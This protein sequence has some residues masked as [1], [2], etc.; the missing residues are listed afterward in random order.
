MDTQRLILFAVFAFSVFMLWEAWQ[1]QHQPPPPVIAQQPATQ[2]A[3][4]PAATPGAGAGAAKT[5]E[6]PGTTAAAAPTAASERVKVKT[7]LLEAVIDTRGGAIEELTLL[8]HR[9]AL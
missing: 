9:A 2:P 3:A 6:V 7:D 5:A 1:R 4:P 8:R